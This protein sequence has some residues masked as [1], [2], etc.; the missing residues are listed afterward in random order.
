M[1]L[2]NYKRQQRNFCFKKEMKCISFFILLSEKER[3]P[4][5]DLCISPR[6]SLSY[7][8]TSPSKIGIKAY[9]KIHQPCGTMVA[10]D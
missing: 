6:N 8:F 1:P 7:K 3:K 9:E 5:T 4:E 10:H 2:F